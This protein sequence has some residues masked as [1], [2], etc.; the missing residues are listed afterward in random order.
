MILDTIAASARKRVDAL[1]DTVPFDAVKARALSLPKGDFVFERALSGPELA[2]IC[3]VKKASPSKGVI[4][5]DFPYLDIARSYGQ[6]GAAAISVLTEP[7]Y[8]LGG[9]AILADIRKAVRVPL[10]RKDFTVDLYQ[11]YEAKILGADAVLLICALL[12]D[13]FL[14]EA[15]AV[16]DALGLSALAEAH[17]ER[18]VDAALRAGTRIV[19]VNNRDL[20]TFEVDLQTCVRLRD[21]VPDGVLYVAES[22]IRTAKDIALLRQARADAALIGETL[23]RAPSIVAAMDELRGDLGCGS[24]F[25][26]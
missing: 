17:D 15:L 24:R 16:C 22:G 8:F 4:A 9:D 5:P 7:E 23:M 18:E 13:A 21:R 2:L 25:A 14:R 12:D 26:D 6:G 19:G 3:E 1:K 20:R 10:L 11:I